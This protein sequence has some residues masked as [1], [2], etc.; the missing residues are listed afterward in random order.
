MLP[1]FSAY[2][3][4]IVADCILIYRLCSLGE[5]E[6]AVFGCF[7]I[8]HISKLTFQVALQL[9]LFL[10]KMWLPWILMRRDSLSVEWVN[11]PNPRVKFCMFYFYNENW[12][13]PSRYL[14]VQ[15]QQWKHQD[16]VIEGHSGV[17]IVNF[18]LWCP[19]H[20]IKTLELTCFWCEVFV[21]F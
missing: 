16:D 4:T 8:N 3:V 14:L 9:M 5:F 10:K 19:K 6:I 20:T 12:I 13:L 1:V 18:E 21:C 2:T 11:Y 17:F 7:R 15:S